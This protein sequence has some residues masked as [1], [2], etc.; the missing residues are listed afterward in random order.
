[1]ETANDVR[2]ELERLAVATK[3][4]VQAEALNFSEH[5]TDNNPLFDIP[6]FLDDAV[7]LPRL[8]YLYK[9]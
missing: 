9:N 8:R 1:M 3:T 5:G 2:R 7:S 4:D 6:S